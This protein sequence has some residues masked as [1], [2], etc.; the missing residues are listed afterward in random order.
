[1]KLA[2]PVGSDGIHAGTCDGQGVRF[3]LGIETTTAQRR[4]DN[5]LTIQS[6]F[7]ADRYRHHPEPSPAVTLFGSYTDGADMLPVVTS[8]WPSTQPD[9][10]P[11]LKLER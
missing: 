1:M 7:E 6:E 5:V 11:I 3:S 4:V 8:I 9:P 10:V 2:T